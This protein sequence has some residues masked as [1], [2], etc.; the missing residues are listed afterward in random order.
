MYTLDNIK[1]SPSYRALN[2]NN[3]T[4]QEIVK[5]YNMG[6]AFERKQFFITKTRSNTIVINKPKNV[7]ATK[8]TNTQM[9]TSVDIDSVR[10][11]ALDYIART[12]TYR[13]RDFNLSDMGWKFKFNDRKGANGVCSPSNR[14][15]YL[16]SYII[17]SSTRE[18][19]GWVNTMVHEI[20]HAI[21]HHLGGRGHDIRW[22]DIFLSFGGTG[23][24]CSKDV[25]FGD[26]VNNP[27]SKYTTVCP[28]G[29][30]S[31]SHK[32]S[33]AV[34]EGRRACSKCCNEHN[35]GKFSSDY[36]LKQIQ[37]Y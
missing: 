17:E 35:N 25:T 7:I 12:W 6:S 21:N 16:S 2:R 31:P 8:P 22:R 26:L 18:M 29:H 23:D 20:A 19:S 33:S 32:R 14:T 27:I 10:D 28:N 4:D 37:N 1:E 9:C 5:Y 13:G 15:L 30:A 36:V 3:F 24:R 11:M 34:A